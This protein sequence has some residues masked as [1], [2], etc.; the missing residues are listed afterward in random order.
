MAQIE[1]EGHE[2][3]IHGTLESAFDQE[4]FSRTLENLEAAAGHKITGGRQH[5]LR[6]EIPKT[7]IIHEKAGLEYD[8]TLTFAEHEG[9]RNSYC[10][11]FKLYDFA[12]DKM[13]S[14][15]QIPLTVMDSTLFYYRKLDFA[16]SKEVVLNLLDEV[17]R[18]NGIFSLLW[19]NSFFD[20]I[21]FPGIKEYYINLLEDIAS[22][23]ATEF[24]NGKMIVERMEQ[25]KAQA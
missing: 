2:A 21:E 13:I 16:R 17:H 23:A 20:E 14:V 3:G 6:Y 25:I 24:L 5:I 9:F 8:N 22:R 4:A 7:A 19:H 15:W 1:N 10:L 11:P 18:F 12:N